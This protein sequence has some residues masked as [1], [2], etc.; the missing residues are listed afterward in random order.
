VTDAPHANFLPNFLDASASFTPNNS[1]PMTV[2]THLRLL[3]V[4]RSMVSWTREARQPR[5]YR[6]S[7]L[8]NRSR[9]DREAAN[10][11]APDEPAS[12]LTSC[13]S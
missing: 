9:A 11:R 6:G 10:A 13:R 3:R 12:W 5:G 4:A 8:Q 2:V 7:R 1:N